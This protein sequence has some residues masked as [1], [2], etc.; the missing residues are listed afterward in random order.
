[1][2]ILI[3]TLKILDT[4]APSLS[5]KIGYRFMSNPQTKKLRDFEQETLD[6][7]QKDQIKFKDFTIQTYRWNGNAT[8]KALLVHGWEGQAGNFG[9]IVPVLVEKGFCVESFDAPSHGNSSKGN[10]SITD[11]FEIIE[12]FIKRNNYELIITHSFGS[13]ATIF[14]LSNLKANIK[15]II[16]LTTPNRFEDRI[17][18]VIDALG[19]SNRTKNALIKLFEKKTGYD[20]LTL[21]ATDFTQNITAEKVTFIH[22]KNDQAV[23]IEWSKAVHQSWKNSEFIEIEHTG[24]FKMLWSKTTLSILKD[25]I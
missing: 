8:K 7:A 21:N 11:Y 22:D 4:I 20:P 18:M 14:A 6:K 19:L 9:A 12:Q 17:Q 13:V 16:L 15:Q 1:M 25:I 5:A 10:T 23:P 2:Q 3:P 24:H